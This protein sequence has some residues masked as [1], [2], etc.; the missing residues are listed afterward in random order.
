MLDAAKASGALK[1]AED[2]KEVKYYLYL[3]QVCSLNYDALSGCH[4]HHPEVCPQS[5]I[6]QEWTWKLSQ[7]VVKEENYTNEES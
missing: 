4:G 7:M 5:Y 1:T 3:I 2:I 6:A